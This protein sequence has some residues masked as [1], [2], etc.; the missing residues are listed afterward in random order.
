MFFFTP[1]VCG[2]SAVIAKGLKLLRA[3]GVVVLV[4]CVT[5]DSKLDIT[6]DQ[7]I[8]KCA[9]MIGVHNYDQ[10]D[11]KEAVEF[12]SRTPYQN[13]FKTII[14]SPVPLSNFSSALQLAKTMKY[15]RVLLDNSI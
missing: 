12:L 4:G 1:Q 7:L 9:T 11:L 10:A 13:Q 6:G 5:P 2:V 8:R 15:Q 3:G 14:S